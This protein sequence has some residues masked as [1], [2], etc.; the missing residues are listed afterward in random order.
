MG[1]SGRKVNCIRLSADTVIPAKELQNVS[2]TLEEGMKQYGVKIN[3]KKTKVRRVCCVK[4]AIGNHNNIIAKERK[5]QQFEKYRHFDSMLSVVCN[6]KIEER[7][8]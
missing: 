7:Q 2:T 4:K 6:S 1:I 3:V 5:A 8:I